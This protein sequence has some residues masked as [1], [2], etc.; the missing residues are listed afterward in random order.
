MEDKAMNVYIKYRTLTSHGSDLA[1]KTTSPSSRFSVNTDY[2]K[3]PIFQNL[4][5]VSPIFP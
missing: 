4:L 5:I 3:V 1:G 2:V